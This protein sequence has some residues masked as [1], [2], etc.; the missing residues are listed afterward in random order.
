MC[1]TCLLFGVRLKKIIG[2]F[3]LVLVVSLEK[4]T[5]EKQTLNILLDFFTIL[6]LLDFSNS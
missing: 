2:K 3:A 5:D 1:F 4:Y 6:L